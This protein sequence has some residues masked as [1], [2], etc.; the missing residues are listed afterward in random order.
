L[1]FHDEDGNGDGNQGAR[2][3]LASAR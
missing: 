2:R 3:P 1:G